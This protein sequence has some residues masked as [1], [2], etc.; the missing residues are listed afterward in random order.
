MG[1]T[2]IQSIDEEAI[3]FIR[4]AEDDNIKQ[5]FRGHACEA[6]KLIPSI[7]IRRGGENNSEEENFEKFKNSL[8]D[9][10]YLQQELSH[11]DFRFLGLAQQYQAFPTR[12]LDWTD[13]IL[14]ALYFACEKKEFINEDGAIW[15]FPL[16]SNQDRLW[17]NDR[18]ERQTSPFEHDRFK[19]F[20]C[21]PF[22]DDYEMML[23]IAGHQLKF[24]NNRD[25]AQG[26]VMTLHPKL[27]NGEFRSLEDLNQKYG[28]QKFVVPKQCKEQLLK[29]LLGAY[30]ISDGILF[31]G[32]SPSQLKSKMGWR[33]VTSKVLAQRSKNAIL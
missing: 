14:I 28:L 27:K 33:K 22:I 10:G 9:E 18:E 6:Y 20:I 13:K 19:I 15:L 3:E 21:R 16:P 1:L 30:F 29:R 31:N 11:N 23:P 4:K 7:D 26:S 25:E 5:I 32:L 24:G 12:L 2:S 8:K 17:L